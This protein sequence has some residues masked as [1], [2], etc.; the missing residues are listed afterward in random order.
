MF[1]TPECF[2][3]PGLGQPRG[4]FFKEGDI[5]KT[6]ILRSALSC[7]ENTYLWPKSVD[8]NVYVPY[9][10][11]HQYGKYLT[12]VKIWWTHTLSLFEA[13][14]LARLTSLDGQSQ[15]ALLKALLK[16]TC[17]HVTDDMDRITI[18]TGMQ[19]ISSKTCV[20]FIPRTHQQS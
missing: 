14:S 19:D 4:M 16:L 2:I 7:R 20:K 13:L 6:F 3:W 11:S 17:F 8:G 12:F 1:W 10:I 15:Q 5:A 9:I 18:E